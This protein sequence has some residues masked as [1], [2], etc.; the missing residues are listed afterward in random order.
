MIQ[1]VPRYQKSHVQAPGPG[2]KKEVK[3]SLSHIKRPKFVIPPEGLWVNGWSGL[4]S[5]NL[6]S[7]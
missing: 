6:K 4:Y 2:K 1:V 3:W 5:K 7:L